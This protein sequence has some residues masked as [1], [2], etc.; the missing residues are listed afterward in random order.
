MLH[1]IG[2]NVVCRRIELHGYFSTSSD[3]ISTW[4]LKK[5]RVKKPSLLLAC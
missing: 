5:S 1:Q 3:E 4:S 2:S